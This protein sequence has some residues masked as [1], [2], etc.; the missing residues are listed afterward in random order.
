MATTHPLESRRDQLLVKLKR[1]EAAV[2]A[3]RA[4]I[5]E[6]DTAIRVLHRYG[7]LDHI[8]PKQV[9]F[10]ST[11]NLVIIEAKSHKSPGADNVPD[12]IFSVLRDGPLPIAEILKRVRERYNPDIDPNNV[13]PAA[14]RL[15]KAGR[16]NKL[17][18]NYQLPESEEGL[19]DE[20]KPSVDS[21]DVPE[22]SNGVD[23]KSAGASL[24]TSPVGSNPTVSAP[25]SPHHRQLAADF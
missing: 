17:D 9:D 3:A 21:G 1:A 23:S 24:E 15:W 22:W 11:D 25:S 2:T 12:M 19:G 6:L 10:S 5:S 8:L 7:M 13:R 4:E 20:P 18:D 14:W 16:L